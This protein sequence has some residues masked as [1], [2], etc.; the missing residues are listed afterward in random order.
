MFQ[1]KKKYVWLNRGRT[2]PMT[3][4][5][6]EDLDAGTALPVPSEFDG[7]SAPSES[8]AAEG[9][10]S[11]NVGLPENEPDEGL[12][13]AFSPGASGSNSETGNYEQPLFPNSDCEGESNGGGCDKGQLRGEVQARE[14]SLTPQQSQALE[15]MI[16]QAVL[17]AALDDGLKLP[18][19]VGVMASIFSDE[20]LIPVPQLP[21]LNHQIGSSRWRPDADERGQEERPVKRART[22][23][24]TLRMYERAISFRNT[25]SDREIDDTKWNRALEKLYALMISC[26]GTEPSGITFKEGQMAINLRQIRILCG[27]RSPNTVS[28]RA[29]SLVKF[30]LWHRG[31]FYRKQPIPFDHQHIAE[32]VWE[33]HQDGV[34]YS[35]LMSFIESVN[36]AVHVL[37]LP[38]KSP[39]EPLVNAFTK[40]VLDE[41][42]LQR[43]QRK[44]ARPL[45]VSEVLFL[46]SLLGDKTVDLFDRYAAG[47]FLFALY[48]RCRWSDLRKVQDCEFDIGTSESGVVGYLSFQ[49]FSHKTASQVAK[50]GLP[51]PL[52]APVWGLSGPPWALTWRKVAETAQLELGETFRGPVLPAPNASG[53]WTN[54]SAT[55]REATNWLL[56]LL[57]GHSQDL[58]NVSSHSLKATTLSWL[59]KAGSDPH[60]RTILGHHSSRK[61]SLEVYSRDLLAAPLRTLEDILRQIRVGSLHPDLTRSGHIQ[62][63]S[64]PDCREEQP[65]A[66]EKRDD[67]SSSS[68]SSTTSSSSSDEASGEESCPEEKWP[69]LGDAD[70]E[71]RQSKWDD[72]TMYQ[73]RLS[74]IVH[75]E[76]DSET[77]VFKCGL[78]STPDHE[79]VQSTSFLENRKCKRC[80]RVI[81]AS[82]WQKKKEGKEAWSFTDPDIPWTHR[83]HRMWIHRATCCCHMQAFELQCP[84]LKYIIFFSISF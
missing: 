21:K 70:P 14:P 6:N 82:A 50:H 76:A 31:F 79:I 33:K 57:R 15:G 38:V 26:P 10:D 32:Y 83:L 54:R 30:C 24:S 53:S 47:A 80:L 7:E 20:P 62:P 12:S 52:I 17:S 39:D 37:G 63:P 25:L 22:L 51:L 23:P 45:K 78:K 75:A 4:G 40:G 41:K 66:N 81:E 18:W 28:K 48:A 36:F 1:K 5:D 77:R 43:P 3:D 73:H 35:A 46:E 2:G 49:T 13:R 27:S 61:G 55:S 64:K 29:N 11:I 69:A 9:F 58:T 44:Q 42:S 19:E 65:Q 16:N 34:S 8:E 56:E 67:R 68:S 59:A 74:K 84:G 60:H 72:F 71:V